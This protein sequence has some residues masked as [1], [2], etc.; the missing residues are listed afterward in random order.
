MIQVYKMITWRVH[1]DISMFFK[2]SSLPTYIKFIRNKY[3]PSRVINV[4]N[5]LTLGVVEAQTTNG[6]KIK[7]DKF[8]QDEIFI[9]P[10]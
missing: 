4:W 3:F 1:I 6:F 7:I 2:F 10:F 9:T 5:S 8:W